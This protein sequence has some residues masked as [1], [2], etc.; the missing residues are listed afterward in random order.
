MPTPSHSS[1]TSS[2]C[3]E[4]VLAHLKLLVC[5]EELCAEFNQL[6]EFHWVPL[7]QFSQGVLATLSVLADA[8][9]DKAAFCQGCGNHILSPVHESRDGQGNSAPVPSSTVF[10]RVQSRES[11]PE[12][13]SVSSSSYS[14]SLK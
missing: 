5:F 12:L 10:S 1:P 2:P 4:V 7:Q 6:I 3:E 14:S 8:P 13:E 9:I 11:L